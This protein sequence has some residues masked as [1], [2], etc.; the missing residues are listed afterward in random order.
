VYDQPKEH[1]VFADQT[2]EL[3]PARTTMKQYG[4]SFN[5]RT[6]NAYATNVALIWAP[7]N[8]GDITVNQFA[9]ANTGVQFVH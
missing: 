2:V 5:V 7:G 1:T 4:K 6:G 3:L 8:T 9:N